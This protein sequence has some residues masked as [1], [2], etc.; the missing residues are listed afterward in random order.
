MEVSPGIFPSEPFANGS[1]ALHSRAAIVEIA[2]LLRDLLV[3]RQQQLLPRLQLGSHVLSSSLFGCEILQD[4]VAPVHELDDLLVLLEHNFGSARRLQDA[5]SSVLVCEHLDHLLVDLRIQ[6]DPSTTSEL[7]IGWDVDCD[8]VLVLDQG[9]HD[10]G[11]VLQDLSEHI[12]GATRE[13]S[14]VGKDDQRQALSVVEIPDGLSRLV[15]RVRVPDL[16]SLHLDDISRG[17][18]LRV[19]WDV[20]FAAPRLHRDD[21]NWKASATTTADHDRLA[22]ASHVLVE[23]SF[24]APARHPLPI[25][26]DTTQHVARIVRSLDRLELHLSRDGI[27]GRN[28]G[29]ERGHCCR[30]EG[31]PTDD[32]LDTILV[33]LNQLMCDTIGNHDVR[34]SQL[35]LG[36]VDLL[37]HQ[38][39][40]WF[41]AG[42][43]HGTLDHLDV[44]L[45]KPVQVR[46]NAD[47]STRCVGQSECLLVGTA[48]LAGNET[49]ALE[50][51]DADAALGRGEVLADDRIQHMSGLA[52]HCDLMASHRLLGQ[53]LVV[54]VRQ[55]EVLETLHGVVLVH[56]RDLHQRLQ[57]IDTTNSSTRVARDVN[58]GNALGTCQFGCL[59]EESV[60]DSAEGT[61]LDGD[62]VS[63]QD[64]LSASRILWSSECQLPCHHAD[65]VGAILFLFDEGFA[66]AVEGQF[67]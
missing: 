9:I 29:W 43:N 3:Q 57:L 51:L 18:F 19:G 15:S 2:I 44:P 12:T 24:V 38:L 47:R 65:L 49:A 59:V 58:P 23:R 60:L 46:T 30:H 42:Q 66:V 16:A 25:D 31:Q 8:G 35:V 20:L 13:A 11:S 45:T 64:N 1:Q 62:V 50:A 26:H 61:T 28:H 22:P 27:L 7:S 48:G 14:P 32:G 6:H 33:V 10:H 17:G 54:R 5:S 63:N 67:H 37:S 41:G 21:A 34:A 40:Q 56:P 55:V 52:I 36:G 39:V 53:A 4:M